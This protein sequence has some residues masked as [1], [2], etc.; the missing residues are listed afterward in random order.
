MDEITTEQW[1]A[2]ASKYVLKAAGLDKEVDR[3][4]IEL[5][6]AGECIATLRAE[7][8]KKEANDE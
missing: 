7:A 5:K 1:M 4:K 3:L 8:K 2:F 6:L